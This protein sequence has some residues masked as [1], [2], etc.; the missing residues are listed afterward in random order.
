VSRQPGPRKRGVS[1][2]SRTRA[3]RRWTLIASARK[4]LAGRATVSKAP[5]AYDRC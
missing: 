1:R 5:R 3:G 4:S 2:S